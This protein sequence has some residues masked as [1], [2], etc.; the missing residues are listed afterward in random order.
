[1]SQ[2][3]ATAVSADE[4]MA[5]SSPS[6]SQQPPVLSAAALKVVSEARKKF[7]TCMENEVRLI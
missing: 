3:E 6:T 7:N 5:L 1:M 2:S 4:A